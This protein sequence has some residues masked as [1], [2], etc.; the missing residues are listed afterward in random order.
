MR[1]TSRPCTHAGISPTSN[2]SKR[3]DHSVSPLHNNIDL[4][5]TLITP[6]IVE[7]MASSIISPIVSATELCVV[8]RIAQ[9]ASKQWGCFHFQRR[10][11]GTG[12]QPKMRPVSLD[13]ET[14]QV[15]QVH[16]TSR[17]DRMAVS[18]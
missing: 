13:G 16:D 5:S 6:L 10:R 18:K 8:L 15:F 4:F 11:E 12:R 9:T 14:A 2:S 3:D 17:L 7:G 1:S